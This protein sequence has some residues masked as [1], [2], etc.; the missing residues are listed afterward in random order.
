[1]SDDGR[2]VETELGPVWKPAKPKPVSKHDAH[3]AKK[4]ELRQ[5]LSRWKS[6]TGISAYYFPY[7]VGKAWLGEGRA[8]RMTYI[9]KVGV[10]DCFVAVLGCV[11]ACEVKTGAADL[12]ALQA[13]F[14]DRWTKTGNPHIVYRQ[15]SDL[16]DVLDR[17]A[18]ERDTR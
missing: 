14:R 17:L 3:S 8:K 7:F 4:A 13:V 15:P 1:M 9:G 16:T 6:R 5:T 11:I 12:G 18:R 2:W 10:A